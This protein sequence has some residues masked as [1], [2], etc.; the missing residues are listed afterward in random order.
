MRYPT[1]RRG[2]VRFRA[3][4]QQGLAVRL[5]RPD[6][7]QRLFEILALP[8]QDCLMLRQHIQV[9]A[10]LRFSVARAVVHVDQA[11][12]FGEL[13]SQP[14]TAQCQ[15]EPGSVTR[16]IDPVASLPDRTDDTLVLVESNGAWRDGKFARQRGNGPGRGSHSPD[17]SLRKRQI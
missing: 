11:A 4:R 13:Q 8:F 16:M 1:S 2:A 7:G 15:L 9:V 10:Q 5:L 17:G 6:F 3:A 14:L 12:Y